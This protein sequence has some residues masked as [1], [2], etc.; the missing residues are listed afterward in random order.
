M[1]KSI[2]QLIVSLLICLFPF[3]IFAE[4][5]FFYHT[6]NFGTPMAMTNMAGT[7]VWRTDELPFGEEY[8]GGT[9]EISAQNDRRFLGKE[10]DEETGLIYMGARY[11]DPATGRFNRPDPV[12]L[13]DPATGQVNQEM[14]LDPQRQNRYVYGLNNPYRYVDPDGNSPGETDGTIA[15]RKE[16]SGVAARSLQRSRQFADFATAVGSAGLIRG[17]GIKGSN[18]LRNKP[19]SPLK[20]AKGRAHSIIEKLGKN[21]Q[22]TTHNNDG[23]WK[24]YRGAGR[25]HGGIPRPNVKEAGKNVTP[26]G[27][28]FIDKGRVRPARRDEIPGGKR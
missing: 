13:V 2:Q 4:E 15:L 22:Y 23:T 10:K 11:L 16:A 6:D 18:K 1:N 12:G 28:T 8:S 14:L 27:R 19:P 7:V 21:G 3:S 20:S 17:M 26:D 5:V 9:E 25:D 24:Q